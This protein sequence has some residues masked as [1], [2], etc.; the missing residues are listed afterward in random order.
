MSVITGT[1]SNE[2]GIAAFLKKSPLAW[3]RLPSFGLPAAIWATNPNSLEES[4]EII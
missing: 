3:L 1:L 4:K 2:K